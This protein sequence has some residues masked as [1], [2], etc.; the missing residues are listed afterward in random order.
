MRTGWLTLAPRT[1]PHG[2]T[3]G[4]DLPSCFCPKPLKP[5]SRYLTGA[6]RSRRGGTHSLTPL[7]AALS[8][9]ARQV[10][11]PHTAWRWQGGKGPE[12]WE[13]PGEERPPVKIPEPPSK[14]TQRTGQGPQGSRSLHEVRGPGRG[15]TPGFP[16]CPCHRAL[17]PT[18]TAGSK[19]PGSRPPGRS[20]SQHVR[21]ALETPSR[22]PRPQTQE[23]GASVQF[24]PGPLPT[25]VSA[26]RSLASWSRSS[27]LKVQV[28][29]FLSLGFL[30]R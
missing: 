3:P 8:G 10:V 9:L 25:R 5:P 4:A 7:D 17:G 6:P 2:L 27:C 26:L 30:E 22:C 28:L 29:A 16:G 21:D 1:S 11:Q 13:G 15:S 23:N 14:S 24:D 19:Q 20:G 12:G 18:G